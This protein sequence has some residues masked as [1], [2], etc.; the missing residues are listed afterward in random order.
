MITVHN[1]WLRGFDSQ[2]VAETFGGCEG[3]PFSV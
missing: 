2:A 3:T 1:V